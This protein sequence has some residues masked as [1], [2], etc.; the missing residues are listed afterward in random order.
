MS[1]VFLI[2]RLAVFEP[3][4]LEHER[5][6]QAGF[7]LTV[8]DCQ[9]S[10]DVVERAGDAEVIW[11]SWRGLV[12]PEAMDA[13]PAVRLLI[14]EGVGYDQIDVAAASERGI[15]VANAPTYGTDDVAEHALSLLV[16]WARRVPQLNQILHSGDWR[17][18]ST[19]PIH[20]L[21]GQT[22]G[23]VGVGR[24]GSG[25]A[26]RAKGIG[27]RV[28]GCDPMLSDEELRAREVEPTAFE[29]LLAQSDFVSVHVPL[30]AATRH[31]MNAA[32][33]ARMKPSALLVNTSR[34]PVVDEAALLDALKAGRLAGAALDVFEE[35]PL[36]ASSGLRELEQVL[37]TPHAAGFSQEA[38]RDLRHE[39]CD[40]SIEFLTTGWAKP[41]VNPEVRSKLRPRH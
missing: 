6:S 34:G 18:A 35:E 25:L 38:F 15:A 21:R 14:R 31:L 36:A 30:S 24:I 16:S 22:L 9:T 28:L 1:H 26:R 33:L 29:D 41:I 20:R 19:Y 27:L 12:T 37:L 2:D 13:L 17:S 39:M 10:A 11:I 4:D 5:L 40:T 3:Y 8:D 32:A 7:S 23:I